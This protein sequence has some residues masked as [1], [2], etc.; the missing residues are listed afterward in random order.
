MK[1][2]I[3]TEGLTKKYKD[4]IAVDC[5]DLAIEKGELF[6]L[7]GVNGAGKTTTIKM[8]TTLTEPD[9]GNAFLNGKSIITD[10]DEVKRI[11]GV[12]PQQTAVAPNLS[13]L[14]NL[15]F[16]CGVYGFN[17]VKRAQKVKELSD[18]LGLGS[19]MKKKAGKLSG[20]F[21]RR[22]SIALSLIGEP[23]ILFLDEPT[24]G[25][26]VI[27]RSELWDIIKALK[28]KVTITLT[29]HYMEE[30]ESLADRVGIMKDGKL[31]TLGT[32]EEIKEMTGKDRFEEAF[33]AV[34][35][36]ERRE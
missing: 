28:S 14:E 36:G 11:I 4:L 15:E 23:E 9:S 5:L 27:A 16:M 18:K 30:A 31:L 3:K 1:Y 26:D 6:A 35:K 32:V 25:L 12:S 33:I 8:L 10:S 17:K 29:T 2:A 21:Q 34:V 20:G 22:L 19:V 24:L 7:L 13:V